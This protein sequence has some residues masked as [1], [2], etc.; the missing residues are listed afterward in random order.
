MT[1]IEAIK[2][3]QARPESVKA[4]S[5]VMN[6]YVNVARSHGQRSPDTQERREIEALIQILENQLF[7]PALTAK[8][9]SE[10]LDYVEKLQTARDVLAG[11][12]PASIQSASQHLSRKMQSS[13]SD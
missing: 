1:Y 9:K 2:D 11:K 8:D 6:S 12:S 5:K 13:H 4:L 10:L 7:S 3:V